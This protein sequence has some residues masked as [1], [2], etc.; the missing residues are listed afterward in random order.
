MRINFEDDPSTYYLLE[1]IP[2]YAKVELNSYQQADEFELKLDYS[3][4]PVDPRMI[5]TCGLG[6]WMGN[7]DGLGKLITNEPNDCLLTGFAD[8]FQLDLSQ[9]QTITIKGRDFTGVLLDNKWFHGNLPLD[10]ELDDLVRWILSHDEAYAAIRVSNRTGTDLPKLSQIKLRSYE[11][12]T[13]SDQDS[14]W[15]LIYDVCIQAGYIC[16]MKLDELIIQRPKILYSTQ[17]ITHFVYGTN[18]EQLKF[19]K[20]FGRTSGLNVEVRCFDTTSKRT[21]S[22]HYPDPM[23]EKEQMLV[24]SKNLRLNNQTVSTTTVKKKPSVST[25]ETKNY[26]I[27]TFIVSNIRDLRTLKRIAENIWDQLYRK[28]IEGELSTLDLQ[29]IDSQSSLLTIRN[30]DAVSITIGDKFKTVINN[31]PFSQRVDFL[32][33]HQFEPKVANEVAL[34]TEKLDKVF[35]TN[36][37]RYEFDRTQGITISLDFCNYL[38]ASI[39]GLEVRPFGN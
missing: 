24:P 2:E 11:Q 19:K 36:K 22:A 32:I 25:S 20:S 7:A 38:T 13:P 21:L 34:N 37:V 29:A 10:L 15:D 35:Y 39:P 5:K 12:H 17:K 23:I 4:F 30:G 28:Q 33:N 8:D 14:Y 27:T 9:E 6:I 26:E 31:M 18:L 3:V 1:A 16:Y